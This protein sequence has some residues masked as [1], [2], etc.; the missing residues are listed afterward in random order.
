MLCKHEGN[1]VVSMYPFLV[2]MSLFKMIGELEEGPCAD[3]ELRY[4]II[5]TFSSFTIT[6][7]TL[8]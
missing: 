6:L 2:Q 4:L 3:M 1:S 8:Y 5:L 7:H